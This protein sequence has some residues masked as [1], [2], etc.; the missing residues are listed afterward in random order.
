[1]KKEKNAIKNLNVLGAGILC[2]GVTQALLESL[3]GG[4]GELTATGDVHGSF[5]EGKWPGRFSRLSK[6]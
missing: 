5:W 2:N 6:D 1:M 4:D 3:R